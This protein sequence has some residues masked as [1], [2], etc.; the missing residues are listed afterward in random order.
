MHNDTL[1]V[2]AGYVEGMT[3]PISYACGKIQYTALI[4]NTVLKLEAMS[5]K[6]FETSDAASDAT[7]WN[8]TLETAATE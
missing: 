5:W 8:R 1:K 2:P 7:V 4:A 3:L 6:A